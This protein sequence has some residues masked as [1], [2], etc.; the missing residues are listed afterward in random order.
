MSA[1]FVYSRTRPLPLGSFGADLVRPGAQRIFKVE[2]GVDSRSP[3]HLGRA[4]RRAWC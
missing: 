1:A 4:G 3:G 2:I